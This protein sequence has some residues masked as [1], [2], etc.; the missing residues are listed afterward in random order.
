MITGAQVKGFRM[1]N[2]GTKGY[3]RILIPTYENRH[4]KFMWG[5]VQISDTL[6]EKWRT[7]NP[8]ENAGISVCGDFYVFI[9]RQEGRPAVAELAITAQNI[10]IMRTY[11]SGMCDV[12][13]SNCRIIKDPVATQNA[14]FLL[15]AYDNGK[16][17]PDGTPD[18]TVIRLSCF[19]SMRQ[20]IKNMK[21]KKGSTIDVMARYTHDIN[22]KD[23]IDYLNI[24]GAVM[25]VSYTSAKNTKVMDSQQP[26]Q[27]AGDQNGVPHIESPVTP[28][29]PSTPWKLDGIP[30]NNLI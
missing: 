16:M 21:I 12:M 9:N 26:S 7:S 10:E 28:S 15:G 2:D 4:Q 3:I 8:G 30:E 29:R 1:N 20:Q 18:S 25:G 24:N 23:G 22:P 14:T 6:L 19:N 5:T 11:G 17:K 13:I 27:Y